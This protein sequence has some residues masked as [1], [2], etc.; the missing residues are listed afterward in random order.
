MV[1]RN[2][3]FLYQMNSYRSPSLE[4]MTKNQRL[5]QLKCHLFYS[6]N[7]EHVEVL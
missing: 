6:G 5:K 2:K 1:R 3:K 7:L 4:Q